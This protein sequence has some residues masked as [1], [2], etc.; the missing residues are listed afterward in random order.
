MMKAPEQ[1]LQLLYIFCQNLEISSN[2]SNKTFLNL[3]VFNLTNEIEKI[4][5]FITKKKS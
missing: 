2:D 5:P 1:R 3:I 4:K